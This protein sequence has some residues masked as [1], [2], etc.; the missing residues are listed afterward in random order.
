MLVAAVTAVAAKAA[1]AYSD[2]D[3]L[4]KK[5]WENETL[6]AARIRGFYKE[7][8]K[9]TTELQ[10]QLTQLDTYHRIRKQNLEKAV[11]KRKLL[12]K[13]YQR[14][15]APYP[16]QQKAKKAIADSPKKI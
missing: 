13:E 9:L 12:A 1:E 6:T 2:V 11:I 10:K 15:L 4:V 14:T 3:A 8:S 7:L 5:D 16:A